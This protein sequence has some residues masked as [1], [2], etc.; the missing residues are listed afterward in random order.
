M[1]PEIW[2]SVG[3]DYNKHG[4]L[5]CDLCQQVGDEEITIKHLSP[6]E[7]KRMIWEL[8]LAGGTHEVTVNRFDRYLVSTRTWLL[9]P[10]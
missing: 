5:N 4:I 2:I 6:L 8:K 9:L 7:A 10:Y 1:N 3:I